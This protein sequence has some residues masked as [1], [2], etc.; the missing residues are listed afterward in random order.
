MARRSGWS[1]ATDQEAS[2][3]LAG[4]IACITGCIVM[5]LAGAPL[6]VAGGVLIVF[7]LLAAYVTAPER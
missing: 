5:T 2:D 4:L 6:P 7:C 1:N 3:V